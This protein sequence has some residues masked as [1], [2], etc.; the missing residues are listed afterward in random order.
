MQLTE[1]RVSLKP[2]RFFG[3]RQSRFKSLNVENFSNFFI[4]AEAATSRSLL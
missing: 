3:I 1:V 4:L 2:I